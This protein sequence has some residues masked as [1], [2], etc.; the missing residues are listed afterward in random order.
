ML[1]LL[2]IAIPM[3]IFVQ[4]WMKESNPYKAATEYIETNKEIE[5]YVGKVTGY[6][7][8]VSGQ[9]EEM[10]YEGHAFYDISI[11]GEKD[12]VDINIRLKKDSVG[13]KVMNYNLY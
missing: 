11:E 10:Q 12:N 5:K 1:G 8:V 3:M 13:W 9:S 6:G 2:L 4:I 7:W